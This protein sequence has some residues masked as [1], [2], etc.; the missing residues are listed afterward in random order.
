M[1]NAVLRRVELLQTDL[2]DL[3]PAR[4]LD[5]TDRVASTARALRDLMIKVGALDALET[6]SAT[7]T[8]NGA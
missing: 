7:L 4:D 5:V 2:A 3:D 8:T 1:L 6:T